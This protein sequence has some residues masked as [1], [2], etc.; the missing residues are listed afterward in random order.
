MAVHKSVSEDSVTNDEIFS[1]M[2]DT[3]EHEGDGTLHVFVIFGAS[4]SIGYLDELQ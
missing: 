3:I 4:V 2:R 1:K